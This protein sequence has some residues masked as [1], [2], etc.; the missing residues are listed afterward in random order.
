VTPEIVTIHFSNFGYGR[1]H[2]NLLWVQGKKLK[3]YLRDPAL[4]KYALLNQ[5]MRLHSRGIRDRQSR[6]IRLTA[7][8]KPGDVIHVGGR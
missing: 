4:K 6:R 7:T 1:A 2:I 5:A 3:E 8:L